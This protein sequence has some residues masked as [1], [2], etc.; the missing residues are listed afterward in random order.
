MESG[1][2]RW[3]YAWQQL[4]ILLSSLMRLRG[5]QVSQCDREKRLEIASTKRTA[6]FTTGSGKCPASRGKFPSSYSCTRKTA[7]LQ[8][9]DVTVAIKSAVV[10][11]TRHNTSENRRRQAC[12]EPERAETAVSQSAAPFSDP[13]AAELVRLWSTGGAWSRRT[14]HMLSGGSRLE[15]EAEAVHGK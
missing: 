4:I 12:E 14:R 10:M 2:C 5:S 6:L 15:V 1:T 13:L 8:L 9:L 11:Q 3:N 7:N